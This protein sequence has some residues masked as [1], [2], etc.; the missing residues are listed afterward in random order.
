M[1]ISRDD[2][3]EGVIFEEF[4]VS[5]DKLAVAEFVLAEAELTA[6][7]GLGRVRTNV[8]TIALGLKRGAAEEELGRPLTDDDVVWKPIVAHVEQSTGGVV[9]TAEAAS[10]KVLAAA[11]ELS[12]KNGRL[13]E[14]KWGS[15]EWVALARELGHGGDEPANQEG[16]GNE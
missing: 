13:S 10:A 4:Y 12:E 15:P 8:D 9:T 2:I 7:E 3:A 6:R 5:S 1:T 14:L 16:N 11:K